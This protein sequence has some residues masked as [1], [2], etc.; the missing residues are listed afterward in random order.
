[1]RVRR[2]VLT[3]APG[4]GKT[5]LAE[6][7]RERGHC[8][9][10][11][12]AT[13]VIARARA[14][15][16]D[17]PWRDPRFIT[18]ILAVQRDRERQGDAPVRFHDRGPLCTVALARWLGYPEPPVDAG[19]YERDVFLVRPLGYVVRTDARRISYADSLAF[20]AVHEQ[21]YTEHGHRLIDVPA[22][23]VADRVAVI[24]SFLRP[25]DGP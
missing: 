5:T 1:V 12:A 2:F 23:P 22:G 10:A 18:D 9:I 11:E 4:S 7:L 21:V 24:E 14:A 16:V 6:A 25:G 15:G 13:D 8:V 20:A 3:G 19:H 17:E